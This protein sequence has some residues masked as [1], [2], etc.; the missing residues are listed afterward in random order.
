M[1]NK[2]AEDTNRKKNEFGHLRVDNCI[3]TAESVDKYYG[4]ELADFPGKENDKAYNVLRP[5]DE[6]KKSL[7]T[8]ADVPLVDEHFYVGDDTP[9]RE[10]WIGTV[11]SNQ[12]INGKNLESSINV[13]D[14]KG[15][16]LIEKYK[17]GLSCGY[18]YDLEVSP[19]EKDGKKYDLIF[20]NLKCN[21]VAL[22]YK[23]R[24]QGAI[25]ADEH[26]DNQKEK[27]MAKGNDAKYNEKQDIDY[28]ENNLENEVKAV[29]KSHMP[30]K[31]DILEELLETSAKLEKLRNSPD[32]DKKQI[33]E[34]ESGL[35]DLKKKVLE[36]KDKYVQED[37]KQSKTDRDNERTGEM[38][39]EIDSK[40][41]KKMAKDMAMD[42]AADIARKVFK[43]HAQTKDLCD[44]VLG[45]SSFAFDTDIEEMVDRTLKAKGVNFAM[46]KSFNEKYTL[47]EYLASQ[48]V[49][50]QVKPAPLAI[51]SFTRRA[52][53]QLDDEFS[54]R[55]DV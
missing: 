10:R 45:K 42:M 5:L 29:E 4:F 52:E 44:K 7:S 36:M 14:K 25:V 39:K 55:F 33:K 51:D 15:V 22:V 50:K 19:G 21:H 6:I 17:Q 8:Y 24:V 47:L 27:V 32:A 9:N 13:W 37:K 20:R 12:K 43:E 38:F 49:Q 41:M 54:K 18:S 46:D 2:I 35:N 3:L 48:P 34:M 31:E 26:E 16:D 23:G 53:A 1:D 28:E 30:G 11:S 40:E